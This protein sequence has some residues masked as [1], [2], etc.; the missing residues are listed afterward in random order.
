[1]VSGADGF[2]SQRSM[3]VLMDS[4]EA[5]RQQVMNSAEKEGWTVIN[6]DNTDEEEADGDVPDEMED[7]SGGGSFSGAMI[8]SSDPHAANSPGR[9]SVQPGDAW[10]KMPLTVN[11][12]IASIH[13]HELTLSNL[14]GSNSP[15]SRML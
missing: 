14:G 5:K 1:M 3:G 8:R 15:R 7:L 4:E 9:R 2:V 10:R 6:E 13:E 11:V 12:T